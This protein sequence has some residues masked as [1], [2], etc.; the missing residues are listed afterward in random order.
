MQKKNMSLQRNVL[1]LPKRLLGPIQP[2]PVL[3]PTNPERKKNQHE[4][5]LQIKKVHP[6]YVYVLRLS[7]QR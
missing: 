5:R 4:N 2:S 3:S 6:M 7:C 1:P